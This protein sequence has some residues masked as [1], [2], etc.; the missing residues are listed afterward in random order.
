MS[1]CPKGSLLL[2]AN[3]TKIVLLERLTW[4]RVWIPKGCT[5]KTA[6]FSYM[7]CLVLLHKYVFFVEV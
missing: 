3:L 5:E 4:I 6:M 2:P 7:L 1:P